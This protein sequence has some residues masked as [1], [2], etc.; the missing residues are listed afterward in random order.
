[1]IDHIPASA[2]LFTNHLL[3]PMIPC[4][5]DGRGDVD[6]F[7][8]IETLFTIESYACPDGKG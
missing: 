3:I 5:S 6:F 1:M 2:L 7:L 8:M 4:L